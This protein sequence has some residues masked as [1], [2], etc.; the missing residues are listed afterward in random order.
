MRIQHNIPAM[1]AYRNYSN[2]QSA[3][4][5]NL[6]KLSSGYKINRAGDDAAGLA[7]SEKM[8]AQISGLEQAQA[9]AK[10]GISLVQ[11]AEGALTEVHDMLNR[12]VTLA[13]QSANGTYDNEVDRS[14]LQ[15]EINQL[16]S[17][18]DRISKATNFNGIQLLDGSM[19]SGHDTTS[20]T[21]GSDLISDLVQSNAAANVG[22][23]TITHKPLGSE[24]PTQ[25]TVDFNNSFTT[26]TMGDIT[27][28]VDGLELTVD[29]SAITGSGEK[30]EI[31]ASDIAKAFVDKY[32]A[33]GTDASSVE[34]AGA[35]GSMQ[36]F[37]LEL[38][39]GK[40]TRIVFTQ[41][42]APQTDGQVVD[43]HK[44]VDVT[45]LTES[46]SP[47]GGVEGRAAVS[48]EAASG[49]GSTEGTASS[50]SAQANSYYFGST[51]TVEVTKIDGS[52]ASASSAKSLVYSISVSS[53]AT[54]DEKAKLN[55][56]LPSLTLGFR[57]TGKFSENSK[58]IVFHNDLPSGYELK[59]EAASGELKTITAGS[60]PTEINIKTNPTEAEEDT[61]IDAPAADDNDKAS[62]TFYLYDTETGNKVADITVNDDAQTIGTTNKN[63]VT[64]DTAKLTSTATDT[65]KAAL[66]EGGR[67]PSDGDEVKV[68]YNATSS[69]YEITCGNGATVTAESA[70]VK[71]GILTLKD[72]GDNVL[73]TIA[74]NN[75]AATSA[76][77][78]TKYFAAASGTGIT[79]TAATSADGSGANSSEVN[80]GVAYGSKVTMGGTAG[81][82]VSAATDKAAIDFSKLDQDG[83][84][85]QLRKTGKGAA[86]VKNKAIE[87]SSADGATWT[88]KVGS[89]ELG[90]AEGVTYTA[91]GQTE[92]DFGD[93]GKITITDKGATA[94]SDFTTAVKSGLTITDVP[95]TVDGGTL[96]FSGL[97]GY[98]SAIA[99]AAVAVDAGNGEISMLLNGDHFELQ[100]NGKT[101]G[102]SEAVTA[103]DP[104]GKG[105]AADIEF[106]DADGNKL[107]S[108]S[109]KG[110]I[111]A[112][113]TSA[114]SFEGETF[115]SGI[116]VTAPA[117]EL[118]PTPTEPNGSGLTASDTGD[119]TLV[120]QKDATIA[121]GDPAG[122][123]N[124]G[125]Y[126]YVDTNHKVTGL[127]I[128]TPQGA[129][130]DKAITK[131]AL[132]KAINEVDPTAHGMATISY[133]KG[134]DNIVL[135]VGDTIIGVSDWDGKNPTSGKLLT[136]TT[137]TAARDIQ[138]GTLI[139][140]V[141][142]NGANITAAN[143][144]KTDWAV[145]VG[146]TPVEITAGTKAVTAS[147]QAS[148][149]L[150][151]A[152]EKDGAPIDGSNVSVRY[153]GKDWLIE[154]TDE[155][156]KKTVTVTADSAEFWNGTL[157]LKDADG[158]ILVALTASD[159]TD[160]DG[161]AI[162]E[163]KFQET[164]KTPQDIGFKY[165]AKKEENV[166]GKKDYNA[167][168]EVIKNGGAAG[169]NRL[170]STYIK[171]ETFSGLKDGSSLKIGDKTYTF[172]VGKDSKV[173]GE[174]VVDM[175]GWNGD[176]DGFVKEALRQLT[177]TAD[178]N[179][180][181]SVGFQDGK[182]TFTER[183]D[184]QN[185]EGKTKDGSDAVDLSTKDA[186]AKQ[187][188]Y[189]AD[190]QSS[191]H[192]LM[193]QIGDTAADYNQ[194]TVNIKACNTEAIGVADVDI[195]SQE[196]ASA[197]VDKIKNAI[198][199]V[200]NVRGTLGATQNRLDHTLNNLSVMQENIQDAE[201]T[202]RDVDVAKEMMEYTKNNI[203]V[204]SAQAMLAQA[205]QLP[206]GVLQLL[207]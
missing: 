11:T 41:A 73:M 157:N 186:I 38:D 152:L 49:T 173:K 189:A 184:Y 35:D 165:T 203:L 20:W 146:A 88:L 204:Q 179:E 80:T 22:D 182:V 198:N 14:N 197:A 26:S 113:T 92:L 93:L 25:F 27:L 53:D 107:G 84:I 74:S 110:A 97:S 207:Q 142:V 19:D 158:N 140:S 1:S 193:L 170:A 136:F 174:N 145:K 162:D 199:Y 166:Q 187:F 47:A 82:A 191:G 190:G 202:I 77:F 132:L 61:V 68:A 196:S 46:G 156:N 42:N 62:L 86:A 134:L 6:E 29:K 141:Q 160:P 10:D 15:L 169:S 163:A 205:N 108:V 45:G 111:S 37:N 125:A 119:I 105:Q 59:Y 55:S 17:E 106:T 89:V 135:K 148:S 40:D 127:T 57:N 91:N 44:K 63:N 180:M 87:L 50:L 70:E 48:T 9:N 124:T 8:R 12:M 114:A 131:D 109:Y 18:I 23:G 161:N 159:T 75:T 102:T 192:G 206:Q 95:S 121:S 200:S 178:N 31:T 100:V 120:E 54:E 151:E 128:G 185:A 7:I 39:S 112:A 2:N 138:G 143:M 51:G 83:I 201:S 130:E 147:A 167:S 101:I 164:F 33:D 56:S 115:M 183:V 64:F 94:N 118:D 66:E 67:V 13:E 175:T 133:D 144:K 36:K 99:S 103:F 177:V 150:T 171:E 117:Q 34:F 104:N 154:A 52:A 3:L 139:G 194:L 32:G 78:Q 71:N 21:V 149:S 155:E 195:S 81:N 96:D 137:P 72:S 123:A 172:A 16:K 4:A 5:K 129:N 176:E 122:K 126:D 60:S 153:D 58:K 65:L 98:E 168:T 116:K 79:Y 181:F 28:N 90:K 85:D 43:G 24:G 76:D 69:K 30:G 188:S